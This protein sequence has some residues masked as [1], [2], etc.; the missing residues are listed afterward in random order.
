[1]FL[2]FFADG[3]RTLRQWDAA[4]GLSLPG[5]VGLVAKREVAS[6]LRSRRR[7]PWTDA[8]TEDDPL[9][10]AAGPDRL[11]RREIRLHD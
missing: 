2:S 5:F 7:N 9:D 4:R 1:M 8:P 11:L 3:G 6:T 10:Q